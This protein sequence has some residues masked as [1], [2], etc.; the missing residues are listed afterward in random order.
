M[1]RSRAIRLTRS[2]FRDPQ[3]RRFFLDWRK[4]ALR[5]EPLGGP[6]GTDDEESKGYG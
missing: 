5:M 6:N 4:A 1:G 3:G 2:P